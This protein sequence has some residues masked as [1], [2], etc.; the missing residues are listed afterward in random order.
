MVSERNSFPVRVLSF[1]IQP[2]HRQSQDRRP[3]ISHATFTVATAGVSRHLQHHP[4]VPR[5]VT[6]VV[7]RRAD[8]HSGP[9]L[10]ICIVAASAPFVVR[11]RSPSRR[12]ERDL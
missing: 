3:S 8:V 7:E 9:R 4:G 1:R 11:R 12:R 5:L 10:Q 2:L 6:I